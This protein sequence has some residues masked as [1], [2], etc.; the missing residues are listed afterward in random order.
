VELLYIF[1]IKPIVVVRNLFDIVASLH[2]H[3]HREKEAS[4]D[5]NVVTN[6]FYAMSKEEKYDTIIGLLLPWYFQFYVS[7]V[8][9][10][11]YRGFPVKWMSY[12]K[13]FSDKIR[14]IRD[15]LRYYDISVDSGV[16]E[17][18]LRK[19]GGKKLRFNKGIVG[20]G[21]K[22]LTEEQK[23]RIAAYAKFYPDVDFGPIG[24][25]SSA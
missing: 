9:A 3:L 13:I 14:A 6:A 5:G 24:I 16:V 25:V 23:S 2:D 11:K 21:E 7:W 8:V 15:I 19:A 22:E 12:E 10:E 18:K 17:E 1:S 20:R 4:L